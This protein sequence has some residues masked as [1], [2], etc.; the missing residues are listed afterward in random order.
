MS[1]TKNELI[2]L[3]STEWIKDR[4]NEYKIVRINETKKERMKQRENEL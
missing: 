4:K 3:R 1:K 2:N